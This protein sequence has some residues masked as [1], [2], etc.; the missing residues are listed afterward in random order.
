MLASFMTIFTFGAIGDMANV[1]VDVT[2]VMEQPPKYDLWKGVEIAATIVTGREETVSLTSITEELYEMHKRNEVRLPFSP[3]WRGKMTR[4][5]IDDKKAKRK[6]D[7][8]LENWLASYMSRQLKGD[9]RT[10]PQPQPSQ[11]GNRD[12]FVRAYVAYKMEHCNESTR[13][14]YSRKLGGMKDY[15]R[16]LQLEAA[17]IWNEI[18]RR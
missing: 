11:Y 10:N 5:I 17:R 12:A 16:D 3:R 2:V 9:V 15:Q 13:K 1:N 4:P 18:R 6:F 7:A 8:Q 14:K